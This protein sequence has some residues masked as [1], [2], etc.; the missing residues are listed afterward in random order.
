MI[1]IVV[2]I[3]IVVLIMTEVMYDDMIRNADT[4]LSFFWDVT[5]RLFQGQAVRESY[6]VACLTLEGG[7]DRLSLNIFR[8]LSTYAAK[9]PISTKPSNTWR[10][11][12][13]DL[14]W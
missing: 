14:H 6:V 9:H 10:Q 4:R 5:Q 2:N 3:I 13:E 11:H 1:V 12:H 7:T 8:Q